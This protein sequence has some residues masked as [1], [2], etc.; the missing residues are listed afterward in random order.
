MRVVVIVIQ[1]FVSNSNSNMLVKYCEY[2][3]GVRRLSGN[4]IAAGMDRE[5]RIGRD[6]YCVAG[7]SRDIER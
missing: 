1:H 6:R 5:P 3:G 2:W 4:G 7:R